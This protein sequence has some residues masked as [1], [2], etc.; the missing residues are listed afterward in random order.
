M[1]YF[2]CD[3]ELKVSVNYVEYLTKLNNRPHSVPQ[4]TVKTFL[5]FTTP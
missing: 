4:I 1:G 5:V 3:N 2:E